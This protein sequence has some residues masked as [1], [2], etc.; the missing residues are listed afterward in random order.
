MNYKSIGKYTLKN[1]TVFIVENEIERVRDNNDLLNK[2]VMIDDME[3]VVRGVE[4]YAVSIIKKGDK[5]G[6]LV[7]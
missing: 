7:N 4:S 6:L 1:M 5:I 2:K 3:Y